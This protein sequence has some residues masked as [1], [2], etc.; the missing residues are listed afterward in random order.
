MIERF[1]Y[2]RTKMIRMKFD[3][4]KYLF[5]SIIITSFL[6]SGCNNPFK[7]DLSD[8]PSCNIKIDRYEEALFAQ[9]LSESRFQELQESYPLFLG[10]MPLS[11]EQKLQLTNY[12]DDPFLQ[13]LKDESIKAFPNLYHQEKQ[14]DDIFKHLQYYFPSFQ[15]PGIYTYI[16]GS[17]ELPYYQDQTVLVSIDR[18][19][20]FEHE[21]YNMAGIPK[22]IQ[23]RMKPAYFER[24]I[25]ESIA[26]YYIPE[27]SPDESLL[28][29]MIYYGKIIYFIK[30]MY[31]QISDE[32]LFAQTKYH[33]QWLEDKKEN[34]WRY[35][36]E[37]ELLF[38]TDYETYKK[39][40]SDA[41]FTSVLGDDSAPRT[42]RWIGYH[43][44]FKFM[45]NNKVSLAQM[46][47]TQGDQEFLNRS[48]YKP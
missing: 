14:L 44:V 47:Q 40:I 9:S 39:F 43:I 27:P 26:K 29:H 24:D 13:K 41:P 32:V 38:K 28:S 20:G 36:I 23:V 31:P 48:A 12:V 21:F 16:S 8:I 34:L 2:F 1:F 17:Q 10:N 11:E 6:L 7:V 3:K 42:G 33:L 5:L 25:I 18:Y 35:Y 46:L 45:Q 30:S 22:Y 37:N 15:C 4:F 19:F